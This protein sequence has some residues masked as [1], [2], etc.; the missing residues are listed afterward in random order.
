MRSR[1]KG[2]LISVLATD[3]KGRREY[4]WKTRGDAPALNVALFDSSLILDAITAIK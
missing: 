1:P 3:I 2:K 4:Q